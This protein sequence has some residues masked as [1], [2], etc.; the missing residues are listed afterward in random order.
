MPLANHLAETL[1]H[2]IAL[3]GAAFFAMLTLS[4]PLAGLGHVLVLLPY[5]LAKR[6]GTFLEGLGSNLKQIA[7]AFGKD[8]PGDPP[9]SKGGGGAGDGGAPITPQPVTTRDPAPSAYQFLALQLAR[10]RAFTW[11][12]PG[13]ALLKALTPGV[14]ADYRITRRRELTGLAAL[15]AFCL[16]LVGCAAVQKEVNKVE[17]EDVGKAAALGVKA[18]SKT[19]LLYELGVSTGHVPR[20]ADADRECAV[21]Y[22]DAPVAPAPAPEPAPAPDGGAETVA[23]G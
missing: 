17:P 19:C 2:Y 1:Q 20:D 15:L 8:V 16:L 9:S 5:P 7:K 18:A 12:A 3:A 21:F 4:V 14:D 13:G 23:G 22:L 11:V 6:I 10:A